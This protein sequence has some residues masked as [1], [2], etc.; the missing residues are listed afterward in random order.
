[1]LLRDETGA[2]ALERVGDPDE[3][4]AQYRALRELLPKVARARRL[5][6]HRRPPRGRDRRRLR[7]LTSGR[8]VTDWLA[9]RGVEP[10]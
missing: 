7:S 5:L 8:V 6:R 3:L 1:M 10:R 2:E 9:E 4:A